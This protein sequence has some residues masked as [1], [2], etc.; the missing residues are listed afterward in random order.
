MRARFVWRLTLCL[1]GNRARSLHQN[2][3]AP[4]RTPDRV[5]SASQSDTVAAAVKRSRSCNKSADKRRGCIDGGQVDL[6]HRAI[7]FGQG[8]PVGRCTTTFGRTWLPHC[9]SGDYALGGSG[10]RGGTGGER[11]AVCRDASRGR[12]CVELAGQWVVLWH[13]HGHR[14]VA[15]GGGGCAGQRLPCPPGAGPRAVPGVA[16]GG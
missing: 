12:V 8:Q 7:G 16:G 3:K 4:T 2:R 11:R 1:P 9:A 14:R 5:R 6:S 10:G 15:G 13:T